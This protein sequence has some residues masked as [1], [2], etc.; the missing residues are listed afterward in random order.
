MKIT[1]DNL[2][3]LNAVLKIQ[4]MKEDYDAQVQKVLNDYRK[5]VKLQGFRPG[6]VPS[7]HIKKV[8][9]KS[10]LV[11]EINK[12]VSESISKYLAENKLNI[13]GEPLPNEKEQKPIDWDNQTEFEF[14]FDLGIAPEFNINLTKRNKFLYY[15]ILVEDKLVNKNIDSLA[16]RYA[17]QKQVETVENSELLKGNFVQLNKQGKVLEHG[18]S[19]E[20]VLLSLEIIK[21]EEIKKKFTGA[22]KNEII[23][24][25][26]KKA[27]PNN[28]DVASLLSIP[29]KDVEKLASDFQFTITEIL[30]FEKAKINQEL[31]DKVYGKSKVKSEKEFKN[32]IKE[33]IKQSLSSESNYKFKLDIKDRLIEKTNIE[34]PDEFLKRWLTFTN[35]SKYNEEQIEQEFL[36]FKSSLKWQLIKNNI[37]INNNIT[38]SEDEVFEYAKQ[39]VILQTRQ[40]G[41]AKIEA[42]DVEK[43]AYEILNKDEEKR[44]IF[45]TIHEDKIMDFIKNAVN[46]EKK[47]VTAE[48]FN[49][50]F[51]K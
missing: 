14:A 17:T 36:L 27:F 10:V 16:N 43:H 42:K 20:N 45:E 31:F 49:K 15:D 2:D 19:A 1:K 46:V 47:Q 12:I 32:K 13:L 11:E 39:L 35:K 44:K 48:K 6:K 24:F 37:I 22:K 4:I 41:I 25:N 26:P 5:Q 28:M 21:D 33:E 51:E 29:V 30:K 9:G 8:Y 23:V 7:S 38:V 40:Y 3:E 50:L 34:L 18:V